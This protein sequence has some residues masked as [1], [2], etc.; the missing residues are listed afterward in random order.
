MCQSCA[1]GGR[2]CRD[3][4]Q[5]EHL[6][7]DELRPPQD[8]DRPDVHWPD[9]PAPSTLWENYPAAVAGEAVATILE[10]CAEEGPI[11]TN[12][13]ASLPP[14]ARMHALEFRVKSP[15]S[16]ARKIHSRLR[17]DRVVVGEATARDVCGRLTDVVRYTAVY[18][19]HDE[20]PAL[21][22]ST[23]TSLES[24]G[25]K[26]VEAEHS[27]VDGNPYKGVHLLV[28]SPTGRVFEL[29]IHSELSQRAKDEL[30]VDYELERDMDRSWEER[31]AARA[32]MDGLSATVP[33][34]GGLSEMSELSG[35]EVKMKAY[36]NPYGD[37]GGSW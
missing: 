23:V 1:E 4:R 10:A 27:Y 32:R 11:T 14:G 12:H 22:R 16:L 26:L 9:E 17:R 30:H 8:L 3:R 25:Y 35:V 29:Q 20:I 34:P 31:A 18:S 7:L 13:L 37:V 15:S 6:T 28:A 21:A 2:R 19:E 33:T 36:P 24:G 5:L